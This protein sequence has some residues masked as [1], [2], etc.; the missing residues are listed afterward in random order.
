MNVFLTI[1]RRETRALFLSPLAGVVG[2]FFLLLNGALCWFNLMEYQRFNIQ[3]ALS[4]RMQGVEPVFLD[5]N[6]VLIRQS[7]EGISLLI[8]GFLPLI[9]MNLLAEERRTGTLE[10]LM[11]SPVNEGLLVV[12]KWCAAQFYVLCLLV[13]A[14]LSPLFLGLYG[15]LH[16]PTILI[17][18]LGILL[19]SGAFLALILFL[20]SLTHSSIIAAAAGFA[21]MLLLWIVSGFATPGARG[22]PGG[23]LN[24]LSAMRH[25]D[26]FLRGLIDT[27]DITYFLVVTVLGLDLTRRSLVSLR[28]GGG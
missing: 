2:G 27:G 12:G 26:P 28:G 5:F 14:A 21:L 18:L 17:S 24:A 9:G 16:W 6:E 19:T 11:T 4:Y 25:L 20:G 13:A 7:L 22:F 8:L 23:F 3:L 1:F 15:P 10:L